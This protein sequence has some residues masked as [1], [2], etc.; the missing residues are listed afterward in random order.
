MARGTAIEIKEPTPELIEEFRLQP[1][2]TVKGQV[3]GRAWRRIAIE[4]RDGVEL[5]DRQLKALDE[6]RFHAETLDCSPSKDSLDIT[7]G[8]G[9]GGVPSERRLRARGF[10]RQIEPIIETSGGNMTILYM[11]G[12]KGMSFSSIAMEFYGARLVDYIE[13]GKTISRFKPKSHKHV[14]MTRDKFLAAVDAI[15]GYCR[16]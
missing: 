6:F 7:R 3:M 2:R 5:T 13:K 12:L 16:F 15:V 14:G 1:V 9:E 8:Q 11:A 10:M 4:D